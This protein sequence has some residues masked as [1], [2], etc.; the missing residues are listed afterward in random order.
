MAIRALTAYVFLIVLL[1][2]FP[3]TSVAGIAHKSPGQ[4]TLV[5]QADSIG[6]LKQRGIR[7][8]RQ[9]KLEQARKTFLRE[10]ALKKKH[11]ASEAPEIGHTYVN[12][13]VVCKMQGKMDKAL[14]YYNKAD[15][16]YSGHPRVSERKT[17]TNYQNMAN[18]YSLQKDYEKA[19]NYY[20]RALSLFKKDS[21]NN[22][23]RLGMVHNNLGIML[24]EQGEFK[25]AT[26][27]FKKSLQL[28]NETS[29]TSLAGTYGNLGNVYY[30]RNQ[31]ALA[32]RY[33]KKS[34]ELDLQHHGKKSTPVALDYMNYGLLK[35]KKKEYGASRGYLQKALEIILQKRGK[36]HPE[37]SRCYENLGALA[38]TKGKLK[39]SV[40]LYQKALLSLSNNFQD[41]SIYANPQTANVISKTQFLRILKKKASLLRRL[42][43]HPD[44]NL[45]VALASYQKAL[46]VIRELRTGYQNQESKLLMAANER[47]T[48]LNAL[49]TAI[50]LYRRTGR[51]QY[52]REAFRYA[53]AGKAAVLHESMQTSQ[54]L[55]LGNIPDSLRRKEKKLKKHIWTYEELIFEERKRKDPNR[56]KINYWNEEMFRLQKEYESLVQKFEK[57]YP[58]YYALKYNKKAITLKEVQQQVQPDEILVEYVLGRDSL[59]AF[60]IESNQ[61]ALQSM[62]VDSTLPRQILEMRQ[63]LSNRNFSQH[64]RQDFQHYQELS[65]RLYNRLI[66]PLDLVPDKKLTIIPDE[67]LAY[68]PFEILVTRKQSFDGINYQDLAYMI[69]KRQIGY[70]YSAKVLF[71]QPKEKERHGTKLAAFA[72]TYKNIEQ[73]SDFNS[74]TRQQYREKLYPL[75]GIKKEA[76]R[77]TKIIQGDVYSGKEATETRFK[78]TSGQYDILHLAMHTLVNDQNPMYSKMAF[79]QQEN[80]NEDGFL[81]TYEIYNLNLDSRMAVLSS[82]NTGT[83][84]L[85]KGEGVISLAR[86]FK[87]AGCPSIV[88]T[89][90]PVEDNSSIR[91]M[92]YFYQAIAKGQSKDE[93]LRSAKL[94]FLRNSDPLHAHPYFWAG[95]ILIGDQSA[96]YSPSWVWWSLAGGILLILLIA[97]VIF[98]RR[99]INRSV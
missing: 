10:L 92:E 33:L 15:S 95:Y 50:K 71:N 89:M 52:L 49:Y 97:A 13:G 84:K 28:K 18:I 64:N 73:V 41:T 14:A 37:A 34:M 17:A 36:F 32:E 57:K 86:G 4:D 65:H 22:L 72:P 67:V 85:K 30:K 47:E 76:R 19:K 74:P 40:K 21:I 44:K 25:P 2:S 45:R 46:E 62:A 88:M 81:N 98:R 54:A 24:K 96:L 5:L 16:I 99:R 58:R 3:G 83:G 55:Q 56:K 77:I 42:E 78:D 53:E 93:A 48:S 39:Q 9:G 1:L 38:D 27:N 82:C 75:K 6:Q 79:T 8:A 43:K 91:L 69:R 51:Q 26:K 63:F 59:H 35:L 87:Y 11:F 90:W 70:S 29:S 23:D 68:L 80:P 20:Q 94:K 61:A 7:Q 12:L 66:E 60:T 31:L